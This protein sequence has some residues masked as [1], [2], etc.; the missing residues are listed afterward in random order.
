MRPTPPDANRDRNR[1]PT[2]QFVNRKA[3][4][5]DRVL[6]KIDRYQS[7]DRFL[8]KCLTNKVIL[9]SCKITDKLEPSIGNQDDDFLRGYYDLLNNCSKELMIYTAEYCSRK[10]NEFEHQKTTSENELKET[11]DTATFNELQKTFEINQKKT[12]KNTPRD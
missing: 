11:T 8:K 7:H 4:L 3:I 5:H 9:V 6:D 1:G 10:Q 12:S 2:T